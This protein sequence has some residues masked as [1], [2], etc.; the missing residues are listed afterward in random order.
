[1]CLPKRIKAADPA[2]PP[3]PPPTEPISSVPLATPCPKLIPPAAPKVNFL[4]T[5]TD[6]SAIPTSASLL[7]ILTMVS[8]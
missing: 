2:T 6:G 5:N 7:I 4:C 8:K 1:M 3:K